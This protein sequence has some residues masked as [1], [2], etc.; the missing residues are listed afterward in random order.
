VIIDRDLSAIPP[1][2]IDQAAVRLTMVG[3]KV[4]YTAAP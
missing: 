3:G 4:V 1:E 2:T